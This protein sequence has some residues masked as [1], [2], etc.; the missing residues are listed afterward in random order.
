MSITV[1]DLTI[2]RLSNNK[3]FSV[4][5][6]GLGSELESNINLP[7]RR[8][9]QDGLDN[10][11][12]DAEEIAARRATEYIDDEADD[13]EVCPEYE[14]DMQTALQI[15]HKAKEELP[16]CKALAQNAPGKLNK[17]TALTCEIIGVEPFQK[18]ISE[19]SADET[20]QNS[21]EL[22]N[23]QETD[24]Y[25]SNGFWYWDYYQPCDDSDDDD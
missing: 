8:E 24:L 14:E 25:L 4:R 22:H 17:A 20:F 23:T 16:N 21:N 3:I 2:M 9:S 7:G 12:A 1:Y 5:R 18:D 15:A 13:L 6:A 11:D 10:A 19:V